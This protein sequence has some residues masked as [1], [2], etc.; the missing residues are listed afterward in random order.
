MKMLNKNKILNLFFQIKKISE[1]VKLYF[2]TKINKN[3]QKIKKLT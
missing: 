3:I 2:L 1:S